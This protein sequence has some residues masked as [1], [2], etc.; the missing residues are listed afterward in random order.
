MRTE[1]VAVSVALVA[2]LLATKAGATS[3]S[4]T[5]SPAGSATL[6]AIG[7]TTADVLN[8]AV[9]PGAPPM[10]LPVIGIPAAA[11]GLGPGDV[12]NSISFGVGPAGPAF[13]LQ[14]LFSVD[15]AAGGLPGAPPPAHVACEAAAGQALGDVFL[16]QPFGPAL[17]LLNVQTLDGDGVAS[18]FCGGA[19]ASG[20]GVIEPGAPDDLIALEAC[21]E[22]FVYSG[23]V[24]T[25]PVYFTLAPGSP[26]LFAVG[27]TTADI[28]MAPPPGGAAFVFLL[29]GPLGLIGGPPGCAPPVC[30]EIDGVEV[31]AGGPAALFSLS[32]GSPSLGICGLLPGDIFLG[33]APP[34]AAPVI[35]SGILGLLPPDNV[36]AIAINFDGDSDYVSDPCDNC[37]ATSNN[38]QADGDGDGTGDACDGCPAD[39]GKTAPGACGCG[40]PDTD[41]DGDTVADCIDNCPTVSNPAQTDTDGDGLG[42]D[43]DPCTNAGGA[44]DFVAAKP[45]PRLVLRKINTEATPGNDKV[46]LSGEFVSATAF[47][48]LDPLTKGARLRLENGA[49]GTEVDVTLATG[50]YGGKGTA[51]WKLSGSGK[52]WLFKDTTGAPANGVVHFKINDKSNKA[53]NRVQV[54]ARGKDGTYPVVTADSPVN[55][56]AVL[57][58]QASASAGECGETAFIAADCTWNKAQN[59]L[60]CKK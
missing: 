46:T 3:P 24:L 28:L 21:S 57:G 15:G 52:S 9:V 34:C 2:S 37:V 44:R 60:A 7:A 10:P 58:N 53:P 33:P 4:F 49:G 39:P 31:L 35:P 45:K 51:G 1:R 12:V 32:P 22:G 6:G 8:P 20:L 42:D 27:A 25:A 16:S 43:C 17:P 36:D 11:L 47:G 48:S 14:V 38:D 54:V 5:L 13:G 59:T 40:V 50:A 26:T 41:S 29:G 56:T 18:A 23:G 55:A 19:V 30:D